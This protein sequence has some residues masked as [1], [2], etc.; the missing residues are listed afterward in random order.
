MTREVLVP[1][2]EAEIETIRNTGSP[3]GDEKQVE[4]I[5][6]SQQQGVNEVAGAKKIATNKG[7]E[8]PFSKADQMRRSYGF[9]V[10]S[11]VP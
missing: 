7:L 2:I 1:K 5:L 9:P 8:D 6:T 10:C 3:A 11:Y 4:E